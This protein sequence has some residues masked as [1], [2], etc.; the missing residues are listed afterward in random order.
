MDSVQMLEKLEEQEREEEEA[1]EAI[2]QRKDARAKAKEE[3][4]RADAR[5]KEAREAVLT[6]ERPVTDL[7]KSL[8]FVPQQNDAATAA[9]LS[10]SSRSAATWA[11][12]RGRR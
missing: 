11:R 8:K 2:A 10:A 6:L 12:S 4:E 3:K 7:L 9:E 1:R 5:Q